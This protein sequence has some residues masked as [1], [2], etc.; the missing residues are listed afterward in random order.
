M[1]L[2]T[3]PLAAS[4]ILMGSAL[5]D[6]S[7]NGS[8]R[9]ITLLALLT[10][11]LLQI[12]SN[13]AND[14]GDFMK[15]TDNEQRLGNT[16]ALQSGNI[17]PQAMLRAIL[18]FVGLCLASG[19]SLLYVASGGHFSIRF[20]LFFILGIAAIAAAIKYTVGKSAYGY[21][22]FGDV[23]VFVFFGPVAV[24]GVYILHHHIQWSWFSDKF[25]VLPAISMGL[26]SAGVLNT[27]N[28]R[29]ID[30]DR[31]SGKHT[32]VVKVGLENAR[33]YHWGLI[34]GSFLCLLLFI[35]STPLH[36][37]QYLSLLAFFPI[38]KQALSVQKTPPS[39]VF[40]GYLKRL[41]LG[42]LFLVVVFVVIQTI[43]LGIYVSD[44]INKFRY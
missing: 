3:L 34:T 30:N 26:L 27:N 24:L 42:T 32:L 9:T 37:I 33:K 14:Y 5:A 6:L 23:F 15:G 12:L 28:I 10:A 22:G 11:L 44:M 25:M 31:A 2:R 8:D 20:I 19:I 39:P 41:S 7:G 43:A 4:G 40:N 13:L 18:I 16:R 38:F 21:S 29:D 17:S 1:R 36:W 35:V